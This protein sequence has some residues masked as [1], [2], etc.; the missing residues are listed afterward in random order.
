M[1]SPPFLAQVPN[2][3][4][5]P[6]IQ[7]P[8]LHAPDDVHTQLTILLESVFPMSGNLI[9]QRQESG[10]AADH[11]LPHLVLLLCVGIDVLDAAQAGVGFLIV[12]VVAHRIHDLAAQLLDLELVAEQVQIEQR[13]HVLLDRGRLDGL[14][15]E[16][17]DEELK[18]GIL[19]VGQAV[20]F[21]LAGLEVLAVEDAAE[22][23]GVVAQQALVQQPMRVLV[24]H[25]DVH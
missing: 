25:V 15:V 24:A 9:S 23:G 12:I 14:G 18:G 22:E 13:P 8:L 5:R 21:G 4:D 10:H 2:I 3:G 1:L 11:H 20:G 17:A 16:P 19:G 6:L 7:V